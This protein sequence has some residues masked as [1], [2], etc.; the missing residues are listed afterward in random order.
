MATTKASAPPPGVLVPAVT[1]F[2]F[3]EGAFARSERSRL[4]GIAAV[5]IAT[6]LLAA[7]VAAGAFGSV[8]VGSQKDA[9]DSAQSSLMALSVELGTLDAAEGIPTAQINGHVAERTAALRAAVGDEVDSV[10]LLR[11]IWASAPAGVAVTAVL[12]AE[13]APAPA[14]DAAATT[15]TTAAPPTGMG[16]VDVT[17][18]ADGFALISQWTQTLAA[19][20]GLSDVDVSWTGGGDAVEV[21]VTAALNDQALSPRSAATAPSVGAPPAAAAPSTPSTPSVEG[22]N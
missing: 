10:R 5:G 22:G 2:D 14:A 6:V 1:S 4:G 9:F 3:L 11:A 19:T 18:T 13:P 7:T 20:P 17:A 15:T 12:F 8:D 16:T 21:H